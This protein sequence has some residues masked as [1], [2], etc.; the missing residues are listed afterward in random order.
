MLKLSIIVMLSLTQVACCQT[1][2]TS[3]ESLYT[4]N[5]DECV[6][7]DGTGLGTESVAIFEWSKWPHMI[8]SIDGEKCQGSD[9]RGCKKARLLPGR[10]LISYEFQMA[11]VGRISG[12]IELTLKAGHLYEFDNASCYWC[13]PRRYTVWVVDKT[14]GEVVWGKPPDWPMGFYRKL[15]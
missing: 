5:W 7:S 12:T 8:D 13:M 11:R 4:L 3:I 1:I 2:G 9:N 6:S 14:T 15:L 10:H